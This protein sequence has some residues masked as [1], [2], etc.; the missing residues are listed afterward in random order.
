[1]RI[2]R[3]TDSIL[4][5]RQNLVLYMC[6][7]TVACI[8]N[9]TSHMSCFWLKRNKSVCLYVCLSVCLSDTGEIV[10]RNHKHIKYPVGQQDSVFGHFW[11]SQCRWRSIPFEHILVVFVCHFICPF[12][13]PSD[14]YFSFFLPYQ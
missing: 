8:V 1:M 4:T 10:Q 9:V 14:T 6:K 5:K 12:A 3:C 11:F 13:P 7:V 2:L